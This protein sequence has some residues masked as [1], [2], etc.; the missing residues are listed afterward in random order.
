[1]NYLSGRA[2]V[3]VAVGEFNSDQHYDIVS[4]N[5]SI[6]VNTSSFDVN[7]LLGSGDGTF[8]VPSA[9]T[10]AAQPESV[11]SAD[12]NHDCLPDFAVATAKGK[13]VSLILAKPG[14]GYQPKV[15][16]P[17]G[18]EARSVIV[19]D[20][21]GDGELDLQVGTDTAMYR[22]AGKGDGTFA[23][24]VSI[25]GTGKPSGQVG[26]DFNGDGLL[27]TA[28]AERDFN[29]CVLVNLGG[30]ATWSTCNKVGA[31]PG[32][33]AA[34]DLNAILPLCA[35]DDLRRAARHELVGRVAIQAGQFDEGQ[36][37]RRAEAVDHVGHAGIGLVLVVM[38]EGDLAHRTTEIGEA[39][40]DEVIG[41]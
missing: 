37:G 5:H 16:Y 31:Y 7:V 6:S 28:I 14:G 3:S 36:D 25:G 10:T 39:V 20:F 34:G 22:L 18:I 8:P 21:L 35:E 40:F 27:D 9:L 24:P 32:M 29:G 1:M 30:K 2:A 23:T 13:A 17:M 38:A 33:L 41:K 26:A 11:T 19:G 4:A 12:F 15:D